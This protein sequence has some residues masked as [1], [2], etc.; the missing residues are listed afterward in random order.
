MEQLVQ[1]EDLEGVRYLFAHSIKYHGDFL[2]F[3]FIDIRHEN[4]QT[5]RG[6]VFQ[7]TAVHENLLISL[8]YAFGNC[9]IQLD[10]RTRINLTDY[11]DDIKIGRASCRERVQDWGAG[12]ALSRKQG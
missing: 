9:Q 1:T 7:R 5:C 4:S 3:E 8:P 10:G 2:V 12:G 11:C 6:N